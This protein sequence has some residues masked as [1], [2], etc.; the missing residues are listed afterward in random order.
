MKRT[1][2]FLARIINNIFEDKIT[3]YAAQ[4]SFFIVIS[5][6]PIIMLLI[7]TIQFL[8]PLSR[9][10]VVSTILAVLPDSQDLQNLVVGLINDVYTNSAGT[11]ISVSTI[12]VLWSAS[13]SIY[14]LQQGL[15][16]IAHIKETRNVVVQRLLSIVYT[17]AFVF[18]LIFS[19][20][21]LLF[22]N[23]L[24]LLL[25]SWLPH[26]AHFSSFIILFRTSLSIALFMLLSLIH[27]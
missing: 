14:S 22:G 24:Q 18:V 10:T 19:I 23:R 7:P 12:T 4:V 17:V 27:I 8:I 25:E 16:T 3:V 1:R 21:V 15:N 5:A 11:I 6:I 2:L 13:K 9:E 26:L 20:G